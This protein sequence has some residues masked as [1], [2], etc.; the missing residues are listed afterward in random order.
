MY[1]LV[2]PFRWIHFIKGGRNHNNFRERVAPLKWYEHIKLLV[3]YLSIPFNLQYVLYI[4][5]G[6]IG[7]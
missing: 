5:L 6:G 7:N 3:M 2:A 1:L 4:I